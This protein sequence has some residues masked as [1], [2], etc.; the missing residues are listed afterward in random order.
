MT[1][2]PKRVRAILKAGMRGADLVKQLLTFARA[3]E[4]EIRPININE[5]VDEIVKLIH[6]TF[7]KSIVVHSDPGG[8][9]PAIAGDAT[10]I[11]Q[12][13]LNLCVNARDAMPHGGTITIRTSVESGTAVRLTHPS[14]VA[15]KYVVLSVADTGI[16]MDEATQQRIFEPFFTTK[17]RG[18]GT[19]LGLST[20]F[21][22]MESHNGF[23]ELHSEA[24]QGTEF[25]CSFPV[26]DDDR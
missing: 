24:G 7:P 6:E 22:I 14:A 23:V 18:K 16:G 4:V 5:I 15:Q 12:V 11:H 2:L 10:H 9:L 21:G 3:G 20:V 26:P 19:G 1:L 13:L 8:G 17:E 25:S